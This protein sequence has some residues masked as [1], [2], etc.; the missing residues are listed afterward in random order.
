MDR[1]E[2]P[3]G[4]S[5]A[6]EATARVRHPETRD[7]VGTGWLLDGGV[8][9]TCAH[10][11]KQIHSQSAGV[12]SKVEVEFPFAELPFV[13]RPLFARVAASGWGPNFGHDIDVAILRLEGDSGPTIGWRSVRDI[14]EHDEEDL[15]CF[16]F[17]IGLD[18]AGHNVELRLSRNAAETPKRLATARLSDHRG[19]LYGRGGCSG[20]PVTDKAGRVVGIYKGAREAP[21]EAGAREYVARF[22]LVAAI[23]EV[24]DAVSRAASARGVESSTYAYVTGLIEAAL[25]N[26]PDFQRAV[27]TERLPKKFEVHLRELRQLIMDPGRVD[28][29]C[30][31]LAGLDAAWREAREKGK[32]DCFG[33]AHFGALPRLLGEFSARITEIASDGR[34]DVPNDWDENERL[35]HAEEARRLLVAIDERIEYLKDRSSAMPEGPRRAASRQLRRIRDLLT[36]ESLSLS[37]LNDIRAALEA[38]D[39]D[40]FHEVIIACQLV[41]GRHA[42][43]LPD[44]AIFRERLKGGYA[45]PEMVVVPAGSFLMGSHLG[46]SELP[47]NDKASYD[48]I[49][50][51]IGKRRMRISKR[52]SLG[53]YPVTFAE[54]ETFCAATGQ[55]TPSD[56]RWGR[57]RRPVINVSWDEA[58]AYIDWLNGELSLERDT[59]YRLPSEAEWEYACR[60]GTDTRRWWGDEWDSKKANG[61]LSFER[62]RT[63]PVDHYEANPWGLHDM[64]GN[65]Y[66]WCA[67]VSAENIADLPEGG[68]PNSEPPYPEAPTIGSFRALRGGSWV[69]TPWDL[70]SADRFRFAPVDRSSSVGFRIS[71]TL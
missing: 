21:G 17:G 2:K 55:A 57:A 7:I 11:V 62:G 70:R 13:G 65:V 63:S 52:F 29:A 15:D 56:S 54:Y 69:N 40:I 4:P 36:R 10:V 38:L 50:P 33:S 67:D 60:A 8:V 32:T 12:G 49:V 58:L 34:D 6:K 3:F 42:A 51:G 23:G 9:I 46:E 14:G 71:R 64:I 22:L 16:G 35:P 25:S 61:Q 41:L 53:R 47:K 19:A 31:E 44:H 43:R 39:R 5:S 66:E 59:G 1:R 45:G 48:E 27:N 68:V 20:A 37:M 24:L 26:L 30:E 18:P 28:E